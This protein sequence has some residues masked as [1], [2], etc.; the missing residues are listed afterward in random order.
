MQVHAVTGS[1]HAC[2]SANMGDPAWEV[3]LNGVGNDFCV[4]MWRPD[5]ENHWTMYF[6]TLEAALREYNKWA[7]VPEEVIS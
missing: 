3:T 4:D 5:G 2:S 6:S 1:V 7:K